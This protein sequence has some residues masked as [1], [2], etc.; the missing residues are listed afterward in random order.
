MR[1]F[2]IFI[3][4]TMA[5]GML[6]AQEE[7]LVN[8]DG[9]TRG[10]GGPVAKITTINGQ[11]AILLGGRGGWIFDHRFVIGGGIYTL[12]TEVDA[13]GDILP[14]QGPLDVDF[15]YLG[16]EM[17]YVFRPNALIH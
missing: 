10:F 17:E 8:F 3:L 15:S 14:A 1:P 13:A 9:E 7:T 11:S 4:L 6:H 5:T 2:T 12:V 16:L